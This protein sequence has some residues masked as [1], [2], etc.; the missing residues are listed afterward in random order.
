LH[1]PARRYTAQKRRV[2]L[3][4]G[5]DFWGRG[6]ISR[7]IK[8]AV[9]FAFDNFDI[10]RV[11]ARPFGS[12]LASQRVLAKNGFTMEAHLKQTLSKNG[13]TDDELIYAIR[14]NEWKSLSK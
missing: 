8:Q 4:L 5:E 9:Q 11:F 7:A 2:G 10:D 13:V 6:I 1:P 3:L 14:K 12:N